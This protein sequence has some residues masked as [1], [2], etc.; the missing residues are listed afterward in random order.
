VL[1][2]RRV[3]GLTLIT[4][5]DH[6]ALAGR[7]AESWG[8]EHFATP[9]ARDALICA[10]V[11]HDDG[12][13]HLDSQPTYNP[14]QQRPAH[15]TELPLSE[16]AGPYAR[17]VESVYER[18]RRA[19]AL[20]GMHF[21]GFYTNR[22]GVGAGAASES[23]LALQI[24]AEQEARWTPALR[25]AW[26]N[27]GP[28]SEF[29]AETW[30]AYEVL[31][32]VDLL[33]LALGLMDLERPADGEPVDVTSTLTRVDQ[34]PGARS[35]SGV[36]RAIGDPDRATI[37]VQPIGPG[38]ITLD[39]YPFRQPELHLAVPVRELENRPYESAQV[40]AEAFHAAEPREMVLT[41]SR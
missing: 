14:E 20:V 13:Q 8:N 34:V 11:H 3:S 32:A 18:D 37:T 35:V 6:A 28:R 40:A 23:P 24:V 17:N 41:L 22:W 7:M 27:R 1:V 36:P 12:W 31:Q 15:F 10:A 33:S 26:G 39:P 19:G 9:A 21:S 29:D 30:H 16:S 2:T 25:A 38:S 4:Q 5:P